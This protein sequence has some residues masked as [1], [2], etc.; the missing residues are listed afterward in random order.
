MPRSPNQLSLAR[1]LAAAG[2]SII[3][4]AHAHMLQGSRLARP[5]LVAYGIGNFLWWVPPARPPASWN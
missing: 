1:Q 3:I 5:H 4:G 2:A